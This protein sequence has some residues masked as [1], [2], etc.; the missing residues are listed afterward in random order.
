MATERTVVVRPVFLAEFR[1]PTPEGEEGS[2]AQDAAD[3][4][5]DVLLRLGHQF[6]VGDVTFRW[7]GEVLETMVDGE[8]FE[9]DVGS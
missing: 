5:A 9:T 4:V 6:D 2:V 8:A 7:S 1:V 3:H